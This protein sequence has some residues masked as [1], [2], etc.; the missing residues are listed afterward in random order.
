MAVLLGLLLLGVTTG[1]A[2][3]A[4]LAETPI[5]PTIFGDK[6]E[7]HLSVEPYLFYVYKGRIY[8]AYH[9]EWDHTEKLLDGSSDYIT[10]TIPWQIRLKD[11]HWDD[12]FYENETPDVIT[13][14]SDG[15]VGRPVILGVDI[16]SKIIGGHEFK[17]LR[18][19]IP[20]DDDVSSGYIYIGVRP[21]P[22]YQGLKLTTVMYYIHTYSWGS[23]LNAVGRVAVSLFFPEQ[24]AVRVFGTT[25]VKILSGIVSWSI[26]E[27]I[28]SVTGIKGW[29]KSTTGEANNVIQCVS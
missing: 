25:G 21:K 28:G 20:V 10:I 27:L 6:S 8:L 29:D 1:S 5:Q 23:A 13:Y 19:K 16:K 4:P 26:G 14:P 24:I 17:F 22:E 7:L 3:A 2:M 15:S 12:I 11:G 9:W 18:I